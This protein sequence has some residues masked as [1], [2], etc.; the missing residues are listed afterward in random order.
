MK[1]I[2]IDQYS[3]TRSS[4]EHR[5]MNNIK[6]IYQHAGKCDDQQNPQDM[7]DAAILSN[8]EVV[9]DHSPNV[10]MTPKPVKKPSARKSLCLFTN[11]LAFKPTTAKRRFV[12]AKSRRKSMKVC[13][14]LWTKKSERKGHSKIN[15]Q[16]KSNMYALITRHPQVFQSPISNDCLI[17]MFDDQIEPQLAPKLLLQ[18]SVIELHNSLVIDPN[19]G[20]LK[21]ARDEDDNII[22]SDSTLRSLL[23]PQLKQNSAQYR[24]MCGSECCIYDKSIH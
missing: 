5:C 11:I 15:E 23:P 19:Y 10:H 9:T 7:I 24:V 1:T 2:G 8:P 18:G 12:A 17:V 4:F 6:K 3:F 13:N 21:D 20:G 16:I 14:S 22:I